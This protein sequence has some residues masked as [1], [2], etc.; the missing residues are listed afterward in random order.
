MSVSSGRGKRAEKPFPFPS[1]YYKGVRKM[2]VIGIGII[3][4][5]MFGGVIG[6]CYAVNA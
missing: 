4:M 2:T 5:I 1:N 3:A 6:I